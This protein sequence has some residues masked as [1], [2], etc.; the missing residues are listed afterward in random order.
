MSSTL[1]SDILE[2]VKDD[3][4]AKKLVDYF[5]KRLEENKNETK[6]IAISIAREET[7]YQTNIIKH[8]IRDELRKLA[9]KEDLLLT[10]EEL[11]R[12]IDNK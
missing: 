8:D 1:Y 12:H 5:E 7:Q 2:I 10:K 9:T 3:K 6:E 11:M 4:K